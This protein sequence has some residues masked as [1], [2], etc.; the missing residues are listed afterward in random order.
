MATNV[1]TMAFNLLA[2]ASNLLYSHYGLQQLTG[3]TLPSTTSSQTR[4][5]GPLIWPTKPTSQPTGK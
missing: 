2:M 5:L 1:V 3:P 4:P